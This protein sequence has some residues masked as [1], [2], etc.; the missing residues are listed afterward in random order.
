MTATAASSK[1][2]NPNPQAA[3]PDPAAVRG[4]RSAVPNLRMENDPAMDLL[5]IRPVKRTTNEGVS[6]WDIHASAKAAGIPVTKDQAEKIFEEL[7]K[8][9]KENE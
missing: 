4:T 6:S 1:Q 5:P 3:S 2:K 9:E 8:R 7:I